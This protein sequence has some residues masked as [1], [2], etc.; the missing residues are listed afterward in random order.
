MFRA[1]NQALRPLSDQEFMQL[2]RTT[3]FVVL[4]TMLS[5]TFLGVYLFPSRAAPLAIIVGSCAGLFYIL[6]TGRR[7]SEGRGRRSRLR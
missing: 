7:L 5:L 2:A 4:G 6:T 1:S 3:D